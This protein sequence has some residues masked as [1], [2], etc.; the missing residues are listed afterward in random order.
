[1]EAQAKN[2]TLLIGVKCV[3]VGTGLSVVV[4]SI[5]KSITGEEGTPIPESIIK[6]T[7][8]MPGF[9]IGV[10]IAKIESRIETPT[11]GNFSCRI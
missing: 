1:M 2:W 11:F 3:L 7:D 4:I 9:I 10:I 5:Q 6:E 8:G